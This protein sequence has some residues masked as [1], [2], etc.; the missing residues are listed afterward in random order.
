MLGGQGEL[1][2]GQYWLGGSPPTGSCP[3]PQP[4]ARGSLNLAATPAPSPAPPEAQAGVLVLAP[5]GVPGGCRR[6][7]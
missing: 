1:Q 6:R 7:W 5:L 2:F 3:P 4:E